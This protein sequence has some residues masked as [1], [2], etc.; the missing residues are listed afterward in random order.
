MPTN[1]AVCINN[2]L[3]A[4]QASIPMGPTNDEPAGWI[5]MEDALVLVIYLCG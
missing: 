2:N 4:G 5:N 3:P 1:S